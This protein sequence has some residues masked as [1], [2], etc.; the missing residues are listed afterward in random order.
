[1]T[2]DVRNTLKKRERLSSGIGLS[3]LFAGG[4]Y[5]ST[6]GMRYCFNAGNS[7]PYNRIV[8]SVPKKCFRRAVKRN[9][10]KRRI[11]E[12]YRLN[13]S[14]LP[15]FPDGGTDIL[16]IYST[17]EILDFNA[18]TTAVTTI[19]T[20]VAERITARTTKTRTTPTQ[21]QVNADASST[22]VNADG[23]E[24]TPQDNAGASEAPQ[25]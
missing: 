2:A 18:V 10:L 8:V 3:R 12:A 11:R 9:L 14:L 17:G 23:A 19:L 1:M 20:T 24:S 4:R 15:V 13:K 21:V 22:K 6:E 7:L 25:E 16:F 5:G